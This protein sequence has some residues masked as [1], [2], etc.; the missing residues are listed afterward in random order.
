MNLT[1]PGENDQLLLSSLQILHFQA[2]PSFSHLLYPSKID[3]FVNYNK[4]ILGLILTEIGDPKRSQLS[5]LVTGNPDVETFLTPWLVDRW[6]AELQAKTQNSLF[7]G[8]YFTFES[9]I[10]WLCHCCQWCIWHL[11]D[12]LKSADVSGPFCTLNKCLTCI[13]FARILISK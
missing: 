6:W 11:H 4:A 8:W 13:K 7:S 3:V 10:N 1:C 5:G 12:L 9:T 2:S